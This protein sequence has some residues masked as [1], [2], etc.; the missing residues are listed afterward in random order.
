MLVETRGVGKFF[1]VRH[2]DRMRSGS[3]VRCWN[4]GKGGE[5]SM[6]YNWGR[7]LGICPAV[8]AMFSW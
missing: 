3:M 5:E 1:I 7:G 2:A 8:M 6:L 4:A